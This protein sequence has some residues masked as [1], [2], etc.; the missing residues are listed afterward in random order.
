MSNESIAPP[1]CWGTDQ[2]LVVAGGAIVIAN[3]YVTSGMVMCF[4]HMHLSH[5]LL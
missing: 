1:L 2:V 3:A 4:V 5:C